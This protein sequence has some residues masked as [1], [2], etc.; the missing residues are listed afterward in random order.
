MTTGQ[1]G[2][3]ISEPRTACPVSRSAM[4]ISRLAGAEMAPI[5]GAAVQNKPNF[6][7]LQITL[8]VGYG[9][10]YNEMDRLLR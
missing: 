4:R 8:N 10:I 6:P 9:I 5:R 2:I 1:L 7:R 3:V